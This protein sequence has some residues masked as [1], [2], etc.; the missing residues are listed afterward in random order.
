MPVSTA[1]FDRVLGVTLLQRHET[2]CVFTAK[3]EIVLNLILKLNLN[4]EL[5]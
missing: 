5:K 2:I 4:S 3:Y 1:I